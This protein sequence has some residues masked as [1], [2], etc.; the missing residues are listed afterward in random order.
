ME[1]AFA[2][3]FGLARH[4]FQAFLQFSAWVADVSVTKVSPPF[5]ASSGFTRDHFGGI[6]GPCPLRTAP[7]KSPSPRCATAVRVGY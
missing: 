4:H 6:I 7:K 3:L 5:A 1:Y 2:V